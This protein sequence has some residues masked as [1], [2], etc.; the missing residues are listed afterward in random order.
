MLA[1]L[2]PQ[3]TDRYVALY[4]GDPTDGGS[5]LTLTGYARVAHQDWLTTDNGTD[6]TRENVGEVTFGPFT[7]G[8]PASHW[9]ILDASV[10]GT[11]L[12]SGQIANVGGE[13]I[14]IEITAGDDL[15]FASGGLVITL[16]EG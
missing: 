5:E 4:N 9:G 12:R 13:A 10:A 6:S 7:V 8:G 2:L 11:L 3:G 1:T 16:E 14:T 15:E